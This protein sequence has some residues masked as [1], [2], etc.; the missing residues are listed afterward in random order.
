MGLRSLYIIQSKAHE[1]IHIGSTII[2][3]IP[4][5]RRTRSSVVVGIW[6]YD[7]DSVAEGLSGFQ[8]ILW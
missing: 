2:V 1:Q 5:T 8:L 4:D 7:P 3:V 6:N